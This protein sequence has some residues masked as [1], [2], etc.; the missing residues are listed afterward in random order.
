VVTEASSGIGLAIAQA[1]AAE[2]VRLV[3]GARSQGK[4]DEAAAALGE[5]ATAVRT[6]V[7]DSAEV[8]ALT[9]AGPT[10]QVRSDRH[11]PPPG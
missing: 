5:L 7:T 3:L 8:E 6:D 2:G 9:A 4:L 10:G 11:S 1:L